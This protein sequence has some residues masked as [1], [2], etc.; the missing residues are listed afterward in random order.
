MTLPPLPPVPSPAQAGRDPRTWAL[1]VRAVEP[2]DGAD[3]LWSVRLLAA[4]A[5]RR[6]GTVTG[7]Y[8]DVGEIVG[9]ELAMMLGHAARNRFANLAVIDVHAIGAD[10]DRVAPVAMCLFDLGVRLHA[11]R[12]AGEANAAG[13][14]LDLDQVGRDVLGELAGGPAARTIDLISNAVGT[15]PGLRR[16]AGTE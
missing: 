10:L 5:G 1:Y 12:H 7:I 9:A 11:Y 14:A 3:L 13:V 6:G 2:V 4:M 16:G 8:A 15:A